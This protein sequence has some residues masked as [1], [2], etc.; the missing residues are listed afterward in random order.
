[1]F[2]AKT[3]NKAFIFLFTLVSFLYLQLLAS[4][5]NRIR[6]RF[7]VQYVDI[8]ADKTHYFVLTWS[9]AELVSTS[10]LLFVFRS[11]RIDETIQTHPVCLIYILT[12]F[13]CVVTQFFRI[14]VS[15]FLL[16]AMLTDWMVGCLCMKE[17]IFL[18]RCWRS[19]INSNSGHSARR[20]SDF[21]NEATP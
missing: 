15:P 16:S 21:L 5:C 11:H 8:P 17:M 10:T 13:N 19:G 7:G 18:V 12:R 20:S 4:H 14:I 9:N 2:I 1:M 3:Q 6:F